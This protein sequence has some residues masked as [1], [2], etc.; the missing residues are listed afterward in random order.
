M[1]L[2]LKKDSSWLILELGGDIG[3]TLSCISPFEN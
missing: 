3:A 1:V 2:V